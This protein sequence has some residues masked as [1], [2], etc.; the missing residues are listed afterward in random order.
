MNPKMRV[1]RLVGSGGKGFQ[2][3]QYDMALRYYIS[4]SRPL[5]KDP[6]FKYTFKLFCF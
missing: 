1:T 6:L 2:S 3:C 5:R 4:S